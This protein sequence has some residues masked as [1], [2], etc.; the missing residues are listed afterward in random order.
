MQVELGEVGI[1]GNPAIWDLSSRPHGLLVGETG[2]GK[3]H[4]ARR[5]IEQVDQSGHV[6]I[7]DGKGG[8]DFVE[9]EVS[10]I[11]FGPSEVVNL[12]D[13]VAD[14]VERRTTIIRQTGERTSSDPLLLCVI[15]ELA[16]VQLRRRRED[17]KANRDRR[18]RLQGSLGEIA[19]TG[20]SAN[21]HLLVL[22]QRP[23]ADSLPGAVRD[24]LG[25]R[26]ALGWMSSDGYRMV[27]GTTEIQPPSV[28]KPGHGWISGHEGHRDGPRPFFANESMSR[29]IDTFRWKRGR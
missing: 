2:A 28:L 19:L 13:E 5:I 16:A 9:S 7:A 1:E 6:W 4:L 23:D 24:Q 15:D 17:A 14:E 18:D 20:R 3:T 27:F 22:L 29:P 10:R 25:L 21:V 8:G 11:A 26:I 12:L